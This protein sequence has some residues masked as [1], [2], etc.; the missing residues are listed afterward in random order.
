MSAA[1]EREGHP[2]RLKRNF[3]H[4][5]LRAARLLRRVRL[6]AAVAAAAFLRKALSASGGAGSGAGA[7]MDRAGTGSERVR[8]RGRGLGRPEELRDRLDIL[9]KGVEVSIF[10]VPR[11]R[12]GGRGQVG[13]WST[14]SSLLPMADGDERKWSWNFSSLSFATSR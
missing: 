3:F 1:V 4:P 2:Q 13:I 6:Q 9:C 5:E 10:L 8:G 11:K 7:T 12:K 14:S